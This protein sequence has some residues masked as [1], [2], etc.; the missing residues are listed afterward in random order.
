MG[1]TRPQ[2]ML[3]CPLGSSS[4]LSPK[5]SI[6]GSDSSHRLLHRGALSLSDSYLL[7]DGLTFC[8]RLPGKT[9]APPH[10]SPS[11][12][13]PSD[14]LARQLI[15]N[16][17][18]LALESMRGRPSLRLIGTVHLKDIWLDDT[19]EVYM[20][21]EIHYHHSKT[22]L[23]TIPLVWTIIRRFGFRDIHPMAT[24]SKVYFENTLCLAPLSSVSGGVRKQRTEVGVRVALGDT[25]TRLLSI[26]FV[27]AR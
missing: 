1:A 2:T 6:I 27:L 4:P 22:L 11:M 15:N 8:A 19:G 17:L 12:S 26:Q 20:Y 21:V 5:A 9:G 13:H 16:P 23:Q 18:A 7:L 3:P 25:G 14:L 10:D 24:L